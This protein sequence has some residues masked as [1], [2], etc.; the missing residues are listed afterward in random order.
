MSE[1]DPVGDAEKMI[2]Y[3]FAATGFLAGVVRY[4]VPHLYEWAKSKAR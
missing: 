2:V 3:V 1:E 4:G